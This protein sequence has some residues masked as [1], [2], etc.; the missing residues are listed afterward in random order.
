LWKY[1]DG[2]KKKQYYSKT[3]AKNGHY[4]KCE[5]QEAFNKKSFFFYGNEITIPLT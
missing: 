3:M 1:F 2:K 5:V 4:A